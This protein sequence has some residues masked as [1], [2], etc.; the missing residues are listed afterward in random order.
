MT[1]VPYEIWYQADLGSS[2]IPGRTVIQ[3]SNKILSSAYALI[4]CYDV[5]AAPEPSVLVMGL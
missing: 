3:Q 2:L 4:R 1:L 5:S